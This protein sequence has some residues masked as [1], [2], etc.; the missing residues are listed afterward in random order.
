IAVVA[1]SLNGPQ[2]QAA[3]TNAGTNNTAATNTSTDALL[4]E[5]ESLNGLS[6]AI[7]A[8]DRDEAIVPEMESTLNDL[9]NDA[10]SVSADQALNDTAIA[11]EEQALTNLETAISTSQA[12]ESLADETANA[13]LDTTQ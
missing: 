12:D 5:E 2:Q 1:F 7:N 8:Q 3:N 4:V 6:S 10:G 11:G 13:L 9:E